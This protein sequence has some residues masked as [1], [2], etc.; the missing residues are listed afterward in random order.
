[1]VIYEGGGGEY[2]DP[3]PLSKLSKYNKQYA[4]EQKAAGGGISGN[5]GTWS[6]PNPLQGYGGSGTGGSGE[7]RPEQQPASSTSTPPTNDVSITAQEKAA[8]VSG[9]RA[10]KAELQ[11]VEGERRREINTQL[12]IFGERTAYDESKMENGVIYGKSLRTGEWEPIGRD[13]SSDPTFS[14]EDQPVGLRNYSFEESPTGVRI[15]NESSG[16]VEVGVRGNN[17]E[18]VP[19]ST[20]SLRGPAPTVSTST[21]YDVFRTRGVV[22]DNYGKSLDAEF[23]VLPWDTPVVYEQ[24]SGKTYS[25]AMTRSGRHLSSFGEYDPGRGVFV[26]KADLHYSS[27]VDTVGEVLLGHAYGPSSKSD[28]ARMY[29]E[30]KTDILVANAIGPVK[31]HSYATVTTQGTMLKP[32][33]SVTYDLDAL[34]KLPSGL[35]SVVESSKVNPMPRVG[36]SELRS[37]NPIDTGRDPFG[38]VGFLIPRY[39]A[40]RQWFAPSTYEPLMSHDIGSDY[41][42]LTRNKGETQGE[43]EFR[44]NASQAEIRNYAFVTGTGLVGEAPVG[45]GR[46]FSLI[47]DV[48]MRNAV[49]RGAYTE[50]KMGVSPVIRG[51]SA[52][53]NKLGMR[54]DVRPVYD[55]SVRGAGVAEKL[56]PAVTP[57]LELSATTSIPKEATDIVE[58]ELL[59]TEH[60]VFGGGAAG[61]QYKYTTPRLSRDIDAFVNNP[62]MVESR[63][64]ER[65]GSVGSK[66]DITD[67]HAF[68]EGYPVKGA[69]PM[70]K[71]EYGEA[72]KGLM[73][74][75]RIFG[76]PIPK[77][78]GSVDI[79]SGRGLTYERLNYLA[80]R[81][82]N[83]L[84]EDIAGI[85]NPLTKSREV[86]RLSNRLG[87]DALDVRSHMTELLAAD[88]IGGGSPV[89]RNRIMMDLD[90]VYGRRVKINIGG[91]ERETTVGQLAWE[92]S[93]KQF[94]LTG[95]TKTEVGGEPF[96]KF[97]LEKAS[98]GYPG[99]IKSRS[100]SII[101][102]A[103]NIGV[104]SYGYGNLLKPSRSSINGMI[105]S[106]SFFSVS[107]GSHLVKPVKTSR[108]PSGIISMKDFGIP[109][110]ITN[111][112]NVKNYRVPSYT[113]GISSPSIPPYKPPGNS[114]IIKS[115]F[116]EYF[117][118]LNNQKKKKRHSTGRTSKKEIWMWGGLSDINLDFG[119]PFKSKKGR[120]GRRR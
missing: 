103:A 38:P 106:K 12:D 47:D 91:V 23:F 79:V 85:E 95:T 98:S 63:I 33:F 48:I 13:R 5:T 28:L 69:R 86:S 16:L 96:F 92:E 29:G 65:M 39:A 36:M 113:S 71:V 27:D 82:Y 109:S 112:K 75:T 7:I 66:L 30:D 111:V 21:E 115:P 4:E 1:M 35:A 67:L 3:N 90:K 54:A 94:K 62:K 14:Y 107:S 116:G 15:Y 77:I 59:K 101:K 31:K 58:N 25:L 88:E 34:A 72:P 52:G 18:W 83:A 108:T 114:S 2:K 80:V 55:I 17:G 120:R 84:Y 9:Y 76:D 10:K 44:R 119:L 73:L 19:E 104:A 105:P 93:Q 8:I 37:A 42:S 41:Y 49:T 43:F 110:K 53:L 97:N 89:I 81:K 60:S 51:V 118:G 45:L 57:R 78:P 74:G 11:R 24:G 32:G 99:I 50:L 20:L 40:V 100:G 70:V 87:K 46:S 61:A 102:S 56:E 6:A 64:A 117:D 26:V 22:T 68:P